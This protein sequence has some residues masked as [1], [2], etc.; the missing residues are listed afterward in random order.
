MPTTLTVRLPRLVAGRDLAR[1]LT[2]RLP[3]H[4]QGVEVVL[5]SRELASGSSSFADEIVEQVLAVRK[6]DCL[7]LLGGPGDFATALV[8][9][10]RARG[11]HDRVL[12]SGH[13]L[14]SAS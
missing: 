4:L 13:A 9:G 11:L 7:E 5:D 3:E 10:A 6:A 1:A 2:R 12:A 14:S 8:A